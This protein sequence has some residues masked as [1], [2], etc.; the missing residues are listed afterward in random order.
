MMGSFGLLQSTK[1]TSDSRLS[2]W[3]CNFF[4]ANTKSQKNLKL[5]LLKHPFESILT[6]WPATFVLLEHKYDKMFLEIV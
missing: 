5:Q 1:N 2:N 4:L 6:F 3:T